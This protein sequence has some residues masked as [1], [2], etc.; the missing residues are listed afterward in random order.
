ML[1]NHRNVVALTPDLQLFYRRGTEGVPGRQH[2]RFTLLFE[3]TRQLTDSGGFTHAVHAHH[4]NNKWRF[5]FNIQR[6]I[7]FRKDIAHLFF[8]QAIQRFRIT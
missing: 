4:Q 2:H 1:S 3:L 6:L 8:Q 5:P 7:H